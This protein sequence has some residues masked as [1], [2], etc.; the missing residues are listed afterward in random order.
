MKK[1]NLS[2]LVTKDFLKKE[3]QKR[4][5]SLSTIEEKLI[6]ID[7]EINLTQ[8]IVHVEVAVNAMNIKQ[9]LREE[10]K[11]L[12]YAQLGKLDDIAK[13]LE[14]MREDRI[15]SVHQTS[16]IRDQV[17]N[18]EKRITLLEKI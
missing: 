14:E 4:D 3:F 17:E 16:E 12:H 18:H 15:L 8:K 6:K 1:N 2:E 11:K 10:M 13:Q 9:D 5:K 7:K